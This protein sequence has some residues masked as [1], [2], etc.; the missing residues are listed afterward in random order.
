MA[1]ND[2]KTN[3]T[4]PS[5][6]RLLFG[7][8][9]FVIGFLVPLLTPMVLSSGLSTSF[10]SI[11]AGLLVFGIPELFMLLAVA[12]LGK[13]GF[14][15]LKRYIRLV[16]KVYGP[17]DQ[18][19]KTRYII[20]LIMFFITLLAGIIAPYVLAEKSYYIENLS[21]IATISGVILFISLL[22]LGGNFW[23]KLRSLFFREAFVTIPKKKDAKKK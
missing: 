20:G 3:K 8:L 4:K 12:I 2:I 15:Y 13:S 22:L 11:L 18:V 23:D 6:N 19:G 5:G 17:P 9:V 7:G 14:N 21:L 1:E 16:I 10:K